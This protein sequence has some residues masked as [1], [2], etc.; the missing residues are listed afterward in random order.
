M[1]GPRGISQDDY[2]HSTWH[3]RS[4][5]EARLIHD[6]L[7]RAEGYGRSL[8]DEKADLLLPVEGVRAAIMILQATGQ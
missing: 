6:Y 3:T 2:K 7:V 4:R 8:K 5:A 1:D